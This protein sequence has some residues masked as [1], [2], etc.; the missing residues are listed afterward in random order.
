[1]TSTSVLP[2]NFGRYSFN[3]AQ[4]IRLM[5]NVTLLVIGF[6]DVF[7]F[8]WMFGTSFKTNAE[9]FTQGLSPFPGGAWQFQNYITAWEKAN[10]SQYFVNSVIIS[11]GSTL[12][13]LFFGTL[14]AF[15][16]AVLRPPFE[17]FLV[18]TIALLMFLPHGYTIIP[19]FEIVKLLHLNNSLLGVIVV[20]SA[21]SI[22]FYTMIIYGFMRTIPKELDE[23]AVIDGANA[24][25]RYLHVALPLSAPVLSTVGLLRFMG[26]WNDFFMPLVL[27]L[28]NDKLR[29]L[30][31]GMQA[32]Y[33]AHSTSWTLVA[34]GASISLVP[35]ILI[36]IFMQRYFI[37][38]FAGAMKG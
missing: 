23:A 15:A 24:W 29:P 5:I 17:K 12:Y 6:L 31:V 21:T 16:I 18:G 22:T 9:Y 11:A 13:I 33:S 10:F 27:T 3:S 36:Y 2:K 7:P 37:E 26:S 32:F 20:Q 25:Q 4:F 8:L 1:M 34:T 19:L 30:A 28:G 35:I 14:A 38:A